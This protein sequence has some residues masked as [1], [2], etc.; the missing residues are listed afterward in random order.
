MKGSVAL[1]LEHLTLGREA[2]VQ[3][4]GLTLR[5]GYTNITLGCPNVGKHATTIS[6][7]PQG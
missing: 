5:L 7:H 6:G 2:G 1:W 3:I 4:P